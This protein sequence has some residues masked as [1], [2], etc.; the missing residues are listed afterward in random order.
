E[1]LAFRLRLRDLVPPEERGDQDRVA[2]ARDREELRHALQQPDDDGLEVADHRV[3]VTTRVRVAWNRCQASLGSTDA[4]AAAGGGGAG[5]RSSSVVDA[6][7]L[8]IRK[9]S[10]T[11][12]RITARANSIASRVPVT[13]PSCNAWF[14]IAASCA[15]ADR[16]ATYSMPSEWIPATA[17]CFTAAC[18]FERSRWLARGLAG[19]G[20]APGPHRAA[21]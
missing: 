7:A 6:R 2:E 16:G 5:E 13:T 1:G 17:W 15:P 20:A 12:S 21:P 8:G 4:G 9:A 14:T 19:P 10:D 18:A 3:T 11:A